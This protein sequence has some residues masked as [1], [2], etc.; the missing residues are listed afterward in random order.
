[1]ATTTP[2]LQ[3]QVKPDDIERLEQEAKQTMQRVA[4]ADVTQLDTLMDEIAKRG[5]KTLDRSTQT[6]SM[7]ER[8]LNDLSSGKRSEITGNMLKL[9]TEV[10]ELSRA[11]QLGFFQKLLR[12]SSLQQ[13]VYKYQS[14]KTNVN[15]IVTSLRHGREN[16]EE[17]VVLMRNLKRSSL[18]NVYDLQMLIEYGNRLKALFEAEIAKPENDSR[19]IQLE[20]GLRKVVT[21]LQ[22]YTEMV[23]LYQQ[24]IAG[25]DIINDTNDKLIDAV[26]GAIDKTQH[27][28]SVSVLIAQ[29]IDDQFK[30]IDA[31]NST[32][33]M[34]GNQFAENARMLNESSEKA[35]QALVK[36]AMSLELVERAMSDLFQA[37]DKYENSN[38]Q[39]IQTVSA[40]TAKMTEIN[41]KVG[42]RI[43]I[44]A[45][46]RVDRSS[47]ATIQEPAAKGFLE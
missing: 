8:P 36:P 16:L 22:T 37:M 28:L 31:V 11:K 6:L 17:N 42:Q 27:L 33:E 12:K 5:Q 40:Q 30:V 4:T 21:R 25:T 15:A 1:M 43:G 14:V 35:T 7:L 2:A 41:Q 47:A 18:E 9:R 3:V 24:A 10:E 19:K 29:A 32:N 44:E 20:R 38:R 23:M 13:Y 26:D 46:E 34:L 45:G 39:I